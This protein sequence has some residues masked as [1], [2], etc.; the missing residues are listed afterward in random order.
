MENT[1]VSF[2]NEF[3]PRRPEL[4]RDMLIDIARQR[5]V[6]MST[7]QDAVQLFSGPSGEELR[8]LILEVA[9]LVKTC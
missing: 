6:P 9:K 2:G 4:H 5:N 7:F 3:E 8:A 1:S